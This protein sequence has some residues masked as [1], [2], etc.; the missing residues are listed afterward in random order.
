MTV[1][2]SDLLKKDVDL[3]YGALWAYSP[4]GTTKQALLSKSFMRAVKGDEMVNVSGTQIPMSEVVAR[5]V[6]ESLDSLPFGHIFADKPVLVPLT[7]TA[8]KPPGS[9]WPAMN[10][11]SALTKQGLGSTVSESLKRIQTIPKAAT[12]TSGNRPKADLQKQSQQVQKT[13]PGEPRSIVLVDDVTTSGATMIGSAQLLREVY[14][15][16]LVRGFV[17]I[18]TVSD[19]EKFKKIEEPIFDRIVLYQSGK[20]HRFPD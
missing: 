10:L 12:S 5:V 14:P 18:R 19:P 6:R 9:L 3:Q 16:A 1:K 17:A 4:H 13:L 7:S 15:K 8:L 11:A 20:T 2:F